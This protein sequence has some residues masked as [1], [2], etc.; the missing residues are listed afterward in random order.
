MIRKR[1]AVSVWPGDEV[2]D[3]RAHHASRLKAAGIGPRA[4]GNLGEKE[5][6]ED[7]FKFSSRKPNHVI[8][9]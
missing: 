2:R 8:S 9:L 4:L 5:V 6:G 3:K 1:S 7:A